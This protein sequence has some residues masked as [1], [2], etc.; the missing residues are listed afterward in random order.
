[1]VFLLAS[2]NAPGN[3]TE[4]DRTNPDVFPGIQRFVDKNA[5]VG[6]LR[7]KRDVG[8]S[9][10]FIGF[11][12]TYY[13]FVD[14]Y[15]ELGGFDGRFR[16][17]KQ[18]TFSW[19]VL[20]THSRHRSSFPKRARFATASKT[21]SSTRSITT[22]VAVTSVTSS[23]WWAR[24]RY[25]VPTSASI[26]DSTQT[27]Q[28]GSFATTRAET[29]S[30]TD[31]LAHLHRTST[32]T[33]TGRDV[34][35]TST[36]KH[37]S[38]FNCPADVISARDSIKVT[39][40]F[41]KASLEQSDSPGSNCVVRIRVRLLVKTTSDRRRHGLYVFGGS[42]PSKKYNFNFFRESCWG[43]MDF[44]FGA[45]PKYPRVSPPRC[46]QSA[47]SWTMRYGSAAASCRAPQDP[48]RATS[49]ISTAASL[50]NRRAP[51]REAELYKR[52]TH[53]L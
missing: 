31:L 35:K 39:T 19:Q 28:T 34:R 11:L 5:S 48:G 37:S 27:I 12:T 9:D 42:S 40:A 33:S 3:F 23:R 8:K 38:S 20:G 50:I 52:A 10:S 26:V 15:N 6:I 4:D 13:S 49:G 41:S 36:T 7:L 24:T 18:T 25:Y 21:V 22:R 45:G 30:E 51:Q 46:A 47:R 43:A 16:I 32:P 53:T 14:K 44:D 29:E 1:L 2:D 17:D